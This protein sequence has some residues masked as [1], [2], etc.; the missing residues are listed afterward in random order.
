MKLHAKGF[1]LARY[2]SFFHF[3]FSVWWQFEVLKIKNDFYTDCSLE[4]RCFLEE[5]PVCGASFCVDAGV[6]T[7]VN[8]D[9]QTQVTVDMP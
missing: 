7:V 1:E 9:D 3:F 2:S 4:R 8:A 6:S 5:Q